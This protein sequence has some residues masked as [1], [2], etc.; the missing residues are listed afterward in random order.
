MENTLKDRLDNIKEKIAGACEKSGRPID[1][2]RLIAVTKTHPV[3]TIQQLI[4]LGV[5]DIGENRVQEIESKLPLLSGDF[6]MH[7]IGHLQSNKVGKVL[8]LVQWIQ[9]IDREN[10]ILKIEQFNRDQKIKVLVEVNTSAEAS[11][12]GCAPQNCRELC[13]KIANSSSMQ[14]C[15]LMTIGPLNADESSVRKSFSKLR[16]LGEQVRDL[17]PKVELSMG[18]SM[19]FEWAIQEGST[20]V[21]IGSLLLGE[22]K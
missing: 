19:D 18:M 22:R 16:D 2:V 11:K 21:R 7:M 17:C 14:F 13:E 8:P 4:D 5:K 3:E 6:I 1:S 12:S 20:M 15:G 10:L 9:S